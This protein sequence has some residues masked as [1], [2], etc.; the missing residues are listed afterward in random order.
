MIAAEKYK[1][2]PANTPWPIRKAQSVCT[3]ATTSATQPPAIPST[4]RT[5]TTPATQQETTDMLKQLSTMDTVPDDDPDDDIVLP[6]APQLPW[7]PQIQPKI[8]DKTR[9]QH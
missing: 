1:T 7:P 3:P 5:I 9:H 2:K 8:E 4:S 6:I